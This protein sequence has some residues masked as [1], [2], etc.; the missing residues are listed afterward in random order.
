MALKIVQSL[1]KGKEVSIKH[2]IH[3]E[4]AGWQHP[5]PHGTLH[6]SEVLK[7]EFCPREWAFLDMGLAKKKKEFIG[8]AMR[9]TFDHGRDMEYRLRNEWLRRFMIGFWSCRVCKHDH[10]TFGKVPMAKCPSCGWEQWEYKETRLLSPTSG[11]SGGI[12]GFVDVGQSKAVILEIKSMD[13]D[14]HKKLAAPLADHK[15]RTSLYLRLAD[16]TLM[17]QSDRIN[18]KQ[19]KILYVSKSYGFKDESMKEAGIPDSP[20]SPFKEFSIDRDDSLT[21]DVLNRAKALTLW[22]KLPPDQNPGLPCGVCINGLTKRAQQCC[23]VGPCFSGHHPSTITWLHQGKPA[24]P[25]KPL[26]A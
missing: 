22:R 1:N 23:A 9:I 8:T 12:D 7:G 18:T 11:V 17:K 2:M 10:P 6:A 19:A 20:F 26:I 14:E 24:H 3:K 15:I 25:G 21:D 5:R 16:E 13:K 4:L